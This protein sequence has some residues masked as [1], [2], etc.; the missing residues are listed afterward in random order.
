MRLLGLLALA[1]MASV[2]S[3]CSGGADGDQPATIKEAEQAAQ[4]LAVEATATTG[5]IRGFVVD[6]ALAPLAG[7]SVTLPDGRNTT[8][9]EAGAFAF[10]DLDAGTYFLQ[11]SL[12]GYVEVQQSVDVVAGVDAP[13]AVR[14]LLARIPQ[15][16]PFVEMLSAKIHLTG[17]VWATV[18]GVFG[19]G[20][21]IGNLIGEGN[22]VFRSDITPGGTIAQTELVWEA[23]QPLGEIGAGCGGTFDGDEEVQ[24]ACFEGASPIVARANATGDNLSA[25]AVSYSF[26]ARPFDPAPVGLQFDQA[27]DVFIAVFHNFLPRDGW[28]F[29]GDGEHPLPP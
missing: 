20:V 25:D 29:T 21:S 7:A 27:I 24:T 5:V 13:E 12:D 14:I 19:G 17:A 2:L 23:T 15:A 9:S 8:T 18:P 4:D 10:A 22:Y 26:W 1:V 6:E 11:A 28:T 16:T 3:G